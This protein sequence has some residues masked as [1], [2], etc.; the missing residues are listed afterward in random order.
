MFFEEKKKYVPC[1]CITVK[2]LMTTLEDGLIRTC[3]LPDFSAL[4]MLFNASAKTDVLVIVY[5]YL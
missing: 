1:F 4:L 2:N 5:N 3:L